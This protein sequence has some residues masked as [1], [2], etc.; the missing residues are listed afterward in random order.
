MDSILCIDKFSLVIYGVNI[1]LGCGALLF[2]FLCLKKT[3]FFSLSKEIKNYKYRIKKLSD[4]KSHLKSLKENRIIQN[5]I[6]EIDKLI[7]WTKND[8][9]NNEIEELQTKY[10]KEYKGEKKITLFK[11]YYPTESLV[12]SFLPNFRRYW[13]CIIVL[14]GLLIFQFCCK[15]MHKEKISLIEEVTTY[16]NPESKKRVKLEKEYERKIVKPNSLNFN[17]I[18]DSIRLDSIKNFII[19]STELLK[20]DENISIRSKIDAIFSNSDK[21]DSIKDEIYRVL[22]S[23]EKIDG[24][25]IISNIDSINA[26]F[27]LD[28]LSSLLVKKRVNLLTPSNSIDVKFKRDSIKDAFTNNVEYNQNS[29]HKFLI[30]NIE[31]LKSKRLK[32]EIKLNGVFKKDTL[33]IEK[34]QVNRYSDDLSKYTFNW[35]TNSVNTLTGLFLYLCYLALL[36]ST[37]ERDDKKHIEISRS[38]K[39]GGI[40]LFFGL[41]FID[42]LVSIIDFYSV[43]DYKQ[44]LQFLSYFSGLASS[45]TVFLLAGK[46]DSKLLKSRSVNVYIFLLYVYGAIQPLFF[47]FS[48]VSDKAIAG[49]MF[50]AL[51]LK[52]SLLC[53]FCHLIK[54]DKL[55]I[56]VYELRCLYNS[57]KEEFK[58]IEA[59][60]QTYLPNNR[61]AS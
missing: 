6:N 21:F 53:L 18:R 51:V 10:L 11:G 44:L 58:N 43:I 20:S 40:Y 60:K 59:L 32:L 39:N 12:N 47:I 54:S 17:S 45:F 29:V 34:Q 28:T 46:L 14:Y 23:A 3:L 15:E 61:K 9:Q 24:G 36:L 1:I 41:I 48:D 31:S 55:L 13:F 7:K 37:Q 38:Y 27:K 42:F 16:V 52:I 4:A 8:Y 57:Q 33:V 50:A 19:H 5:H 2:F 26:K 35:L 25:L 30:Q 56:F 49:L 22:C